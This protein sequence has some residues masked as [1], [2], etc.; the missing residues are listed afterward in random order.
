M[1]VDFAISSPLVRPKDASYPVSVR[2][3]AGL[4]HTSFRRHLA[5][6]ALVLR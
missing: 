1:D 2:Q 5:V 4:L 3:I 6:A